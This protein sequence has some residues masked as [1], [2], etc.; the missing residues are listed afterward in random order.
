MKKLSLIILLLPFMVKAQQVTNQPNG[1]EVRT[2]VAIYG[3]PA[4]GK[5]KPHSELSCFS[6]N[7]TG[8]VS[9]MYSLGAHAGRSPE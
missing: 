2:K 6:G 8:P 1:M 5:V 9:R 3:K 7:S 4:P